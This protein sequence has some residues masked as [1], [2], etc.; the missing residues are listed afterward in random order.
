MLAFVRCAEGEGEP[1]ELTTKGDVVRVHALVTACDT[2][3]QSLSDDIDTS[4]ERRR[5]R[6]PSFDQASQVLT[7]RSVII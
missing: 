4:E 2:L 6:R 3:T 7:A 5:V 1:V